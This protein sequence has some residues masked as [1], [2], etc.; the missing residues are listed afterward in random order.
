[1]ANKLAGETSPYLLQHAQNPVD[2]YP[3]GD[4]ALARAQDEDKPIL[5]SIGYAA[6]HWCHVMAHESFEDPATAAIMNRFFV[7]IKV[8]REERPDI[9]SIYMSAIQALHGQGGWPL[10]AFLTPEGR[11]FYGGTYFPPTPRYGTPSFTQVLES[12]ASAWITK[13]DEIE[14][15]AEGIAEHLSQ[16]AAAGQ[17]AGSLNEALFD[18]ALQG[19]M[20][21]FDSQEGGFSSAPKFP[22]SMTIEFLLRTAVQRDE[23]MALHMAEY[24]L[25]KMAYSG[26][27]DQLGGGFA[28]YATDNKWLVPHFEKMLYDNALLARAYLHAYQVTGDPIYRA[29]VEETLDF[30]KRDMRHDNGGF[31]SS[32][33]ADSEGEEG[34]FYVWQADEIRQALGENAPLFMA[35]YGISDAGNWEGSNILNVAEEIGTLSERFN[36]GEDEINSRLQAAKERLLELREERVWPGLDDK[37]LTSWNGL[38]MAAFAEAGR[39]LNRADYTRIAEENARFLDQ[40]MRTE[41]GRL[42]RT[43]KAGSSAKLNG[44]LE[45]YA[46][47]ADGLL[48]LY[49]T[50]FDPYWFEWLE[51]L[52]E[53]ILEH[54]PDRRYGGFFDTPDDHE[55][56]LYR[57]KD[58]QDNATPSGNAMAA[59]VL[60]KLSLYTGKEKLWDMAQD[61]LSKTASFMARFPT[62]FAHWLSAA[63]FALGDPREVAV[64]GALE[65]VGTRALIGAVNKEFRPNLVLAAGEDGDVVP[66]LADRPQVGGKATAYVCRRFICQAPVT[67]EQSLMEQLE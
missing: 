28:R 32:Y 63:A 39:V 3:W 60:L 36:L 7:N 9:D 23:G 31:Y 34:K 49:Q 8:D 26:M 15:S 59:L 56:L 58:I 30:V 13:R 41:G 20:G 51:S 47:L 64:A 12:V 42:L 19:I 22:P 54:F 11:P 14:K 35:R 65:D 27:Y 4:E 67:D 33:D 46:Y 29:I 21:Q 52:A 18:Q 37:V 5:L 16:A 1:M 62:G 43:W 55:D 2:W 24:T 44:Y 57:P 45:D 38:M 50:T 48:A 25:K 66:L 10:T 53:Q 17:E 6:C 40:T 61:A